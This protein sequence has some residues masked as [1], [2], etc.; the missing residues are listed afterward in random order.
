MSPGANIS[1]ALRVQ[2]SGMPRYH[3][4]AC[5]LF[6]DHRSV[7]R[8]GRLLLVAAHA[9]FSVVAG[10][11]QP[12]SGVHVRVMAARA[13][14]RSVEQAD[15]RLRTGSVVAAPD[16]VGAVLRGAELLRNERL[17]GIIVT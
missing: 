8:T 7:C 17:H 6:T 10:I 2:P 12:D 16:P 3:S 5:R 1:P 13:L 14:H 4:G 15:R 9:Q 11:D